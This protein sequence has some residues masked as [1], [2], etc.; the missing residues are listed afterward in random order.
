MELLILKKT[1]M[2]ILLV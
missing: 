1:V 2:E